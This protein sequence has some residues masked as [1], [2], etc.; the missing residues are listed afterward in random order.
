MED[1]SQERKDP[2]R[3]RVPEED[4]PPLRG[5]DLVILR[6]L[7]RGNLRW[8]APTALFLGLAV[9]AGVP[10]PLITMVIIDGVNTATGTFPQLGLWVAL[11]AG[12]VIVG[13]AASFARNYFQA[14]FRQGLAREIRGRVLVHLPK[15][16]PRFFDGEESGYVAARIL[17]DAQT[18]EGM[19]SSQLISVVTDVGKFGGGV[20]ILFF[21]HWKLALVASAVLPLLVLGARIFRRRAGRT[22]DRQMEVSAGFYQDLQET[23]SGI[24]LVKAA[25]REGRSAERLKKALERIFGAEISAVLVQGAASAVL[26]TVAAAGAVIVLWFGAQEILAGRLSIGELF[27]FN[28]YLA[29]LFGPSRSLSYFPVAV[30]PAVVG[31]KRLKYLLG[32]YPERAEGE[33]PGRIEGKVALEDVTFSYDRGTEV[34]RGVTAEIGAGE[35]VGM[36]GPSGAGK[37]TFAKLVLGFYTPDSGKVRIDGKDLAGISLPALRRRA[38]YLGQ[39][40]FFFSDTL[41]ANLVWTRPEASDEDIEEA[42][43]AACA[44]DVV[45]GLEKGLDSRVGERGVRLSGGEKQRLAIAR[46]LL[47]RPDFLLLDEATSFL[48]LETERKV[49]ENLFSRMADRTVLVIAHRLSSLKGLDRILVLDSKGRMVQQ[50][51]REDLM[52]KDG[53]F[54]RLYGTEGE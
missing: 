40:A 21:L 27:A 16:P 14:R 24:M 10:Q 32:L 43:T 48:D 11:F 15:L 18:V 22:F 4:L 35:K 3:L 29:Y 37:S 39:E 50:G 7:V 26:G 12:L 38:G 6:N 17:G 30:Q 13:Q 25:G 2:Y 49:R 47:Q 5:S 36:V 8:L 46:A 45:R 51:T 52:A 1:T 20:V 41:R 53:L 33:D 19:V 28:A 34:L 42:L 31:Y 44:R 54:R 23:L 9:A